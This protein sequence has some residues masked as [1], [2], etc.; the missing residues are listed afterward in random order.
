MVDKVWVQCAKCGKLHKVKN[1]DVL[2]SKDDLYIEII[3]CPRCRDGT[4]HL[5]V[6][7]DKEDV[8]LYGNTFL[9]ERYFIYNTK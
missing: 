9:D 7:E 5:L 3:F 1:K 4:R 6:G 2:I 8:Y